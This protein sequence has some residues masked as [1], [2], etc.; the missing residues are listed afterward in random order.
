[1]DACLPL[2]CMK[3]LIREK[4]FYKHIL[5]IAVPI[6]IQNLLVNIT[7]LAD[8]VMLGNADDT[9]RLLSAASLANQ[10]FFLLTMICFGLSGA[11][12][13]LN[14]QYWGRG[15]PEAIRRVVSLTLKL[16]ALFALAMAA[17]VLIAP[18][19]VMGLY[20]EKTQVIDQGSQYLRIMGWAYL[21]FALSNTMICCLRSVE[22]VKISVA[23]NLCSF[24]T[25]VFLNWVLI[26]GN[27]GAP[28][29]GIRGAAF[30]TLTAR[31]LEFI[32]TFLYVF[33]FDQKLGFRVKHLLSFDRVLLGDLVRHGSPV[34]INEVLWSLGMTVQAA[35]L[36]H[37]EYS[38][39]DPVAANSIASNV[40]QLCTVVIFGVANAAAVA[41]GKAIGERNMEEARRRA[42]TL[43]LLSYGVGA[44]SCAAVFL[45]RNA[46]VS[47][48]GVSAET[49]SLAVELMV[50]TAFVAFFV[51]PSAVN[52][53][54]VLRGAGDTR[55]CLLAEML[56]LWCLA[57]P[58]GLIASLAALPVPLVLACMKMDEPAKVL[59]CA[60]RRRGD[61]WIKIVTRG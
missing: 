35:I 25:N 2:I 37:I 34:F 29:M 26:F 13:V 15:N 20:T 40:Q 55:F 41:V 30:A 28:A 50:V 51:S 32:I 3:Y 5:L 54:G 6:A 14:S 52:I 11:A 31:I 56:A 10:P 21:L 47:L 18:E 4:S 57:V 46:A 8:S 12:T 17:V 1:M 22:V 61:K 59:I 60:V 38:V 7:A 23:V 45:L 42:Y 53:V 16:A 43:N 19:W 39:G 58:A 49:R 36:G 9:G 48:F 24:G 33:C 27:L 44:L